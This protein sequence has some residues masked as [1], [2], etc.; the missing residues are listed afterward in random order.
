MILGRVQVNKRKTTTMFYKRE[1][2]V[3]LERMASTAYCSATERLARNSHFEYI[4][5][6]SLR[7][8]CNTVYK[9]SE[10]VPGDFPRPL[11]HARSKH[12]EC[13]KRIVH[14]PYVKTWQVIIEL[15]K[16]S[17]FIECQAVM[18]WSNTSTLPCATCTDQI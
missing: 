7:N 11:S 15:L 3:A 14:F 4:P 1:L 17:T 8:L 9:Y 10:L 16:M 6:Y 13:R 18:F 5:L 12:F 2:K